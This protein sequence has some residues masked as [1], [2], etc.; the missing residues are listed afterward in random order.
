MNAVQWLRVDAKP[1]GVWNSNTQSL[2]FWWRHTLVI[3]RHVLTHICVR[4]LWMP[5]PVA[6][7]SKCRFVTARLLRLWVR[8]PPEAWMFVCCECC[9]LSRRG[10]C[11]ELITRTEESYRLWWIVVCDLE[12]SWMRRPWPTGGWCAK[13]KQTYGTD[14]MCVFKQAYLLFI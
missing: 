6:V 9:V 12:T 1:S 11:D 5:V 8:I 2:P 14:V 7:R 10:I 3:M 13:N 4:M